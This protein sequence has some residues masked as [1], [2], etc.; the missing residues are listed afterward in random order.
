MAATSNTSGPLAGIHVVDFSVGFAVPGAGMY[1]ADQGA[2]VVK[3]EALESRRSGRNGTYFV[4]NRG[5]R[6]VA[7]D[8]RTPEGKSIAHELVKRSDVMMVTSRPG[9]A[10]RRGLGYEEMSKLNSRLVYAC[11]TGWGNKGPHRMKRGADYVVQAYSGI[12][13]SQPSSDGTPSGTAWY[14]AD[15][16]IPMYLP[17][18]IMLALWQR[19]KTGHGQKVETSQ[20]QAQLAMQMIHLVFNEQGEPVD[21]Q[22]AGT[23]IA[24]SWR[25]PAHTYQAKDGKWLALV[26]LDNDDWRKFWGLMALGEF[27]SDPRITGIWWPPDLIEAYYEKIQACFRA[28]TRD[29][30]IKI[31]EEAGFADTIS[32]V[33]SREEVMKSPQVIENGWAVEQQ[34]PVA[35]K[36]TML[37]TPFSMS[38]N[39]TPVPAVSPE[40]GEHTQEVLTELGY[41][42][43]EIDAFRTKG[44]IN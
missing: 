21:D 35:G 16:S 39:P 11:I 36:I 6:A 31:L 29:E 37:A 18:A 8:L 4:Y 2:D 12:M 20:L 17:Y 1:L 9:D 42:A 15:M 27:P 10:E 22:V 3:I 44:V 28:R 26:S 34:H 38:D 19:E 32:P 30:W 24:W 7:L 25:R 13:A 5:K 43:A 41:S 40:H 23:S 33:L 14:P